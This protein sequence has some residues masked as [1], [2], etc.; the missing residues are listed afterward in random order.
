MILQVTS[1]APCRTAL[2]AIGSGGDE[3]GQEVKGLSKNYPSVRMAF[4]VLFMILTYLILPGTRETINIFIPVLQVEKLRHREIKQLT[5]Q[6]KQNS[7][8]AF[9]LQGPSMTTMLC[10][11]LA[12]IFSY[13]VL[14]Q[15]LVII[16]L[17]S[18][19][20]FRGKLYRIIIT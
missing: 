1:R 6:W 11:P 3:K 16:L 14:V 12:D 4:S 18:T 5:S 19:S 15:I 13:A 17:K 8:P 7:N 20:V 10:S 9:Y 2:S